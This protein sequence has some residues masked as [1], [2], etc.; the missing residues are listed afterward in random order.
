VPIDRAIGRSEAGQVQDVEA[1]SV[2][3][4]DVDWAAPDRD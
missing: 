4:A 3:A 1:F 2:A